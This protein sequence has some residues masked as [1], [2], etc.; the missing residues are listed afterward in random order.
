VVPLS[1]FPPTRSA[2]RRTQTR[3]SS[4]SERRRVAGADCR[5]TMSNSD[6]LS[7][8]LAPGARDM[9]LRSRDAPW[10]PRFASRFKKALPTRPNKMKGGGAPKGAHLL[11]VPSGAR[12]APRRRM[13]PLVRASGALAF[14]RSTAV[15]A[16]PDA[17]GH[18]LSAQ[19]PRFLRPGFVGRYPVSPVSVHRAPRRPV[20]VPVGR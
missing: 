7:F 11:A 2:L 13:L 17:S 20:V 5:S 14:R 12:R 9:R 16:A 15:L 19:S 1:H 10:H 6:A 18:R 4:Q 3:R 8:P